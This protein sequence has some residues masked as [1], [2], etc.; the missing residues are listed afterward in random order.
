MGQKSTCLADSQGGKSVARFI[1]C[2]HA[3]TDVN[4]TPLWGLSRTR[5]S[6][7]SSWG[8]QGPRG[9]SRNSRSP[10][11]RF[12]GNTIEAKAK[13]GKPPPLT[14]RETQAFASKL[15]LQGCHKLLPDSLFLRRRRRKGKERGFEQLDVGS[16]PESTVSCL[17]GNSG[18]LLRSLPTCPEPQCNAI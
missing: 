4:V 9:N 7:C 18:L 17:L 8:L 3:A 1:L 13:P 15:P 16:L 10:S 6:L 14:S 2:C 11:Q 5:S 12:M